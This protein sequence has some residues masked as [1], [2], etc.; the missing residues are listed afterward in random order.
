MA[1]ERARRSDE[2][3]AIR[4]AIDLGMTVLDTA[5]MYADG[6][7]EELV[8]EAIA[9]RR[10]RAFLVDRVLPIHARRRN[11]IAACERSLRRLDTDHLDLYLLHW[12]ETTPLEE[13]VGA[14]Q[15]LVDD[16]KIRY[17]GV[18][19]F[20]LSDMDELVSL[21]GG[22]DVATD[23]VLYNLA[24]RGIEYDL[25]PWCLARNIPVMAYS[26]IQQGRLLD[27]FELKQVAARHNATPAQI[28]LAWV[29]RLD[30]I[31][32]IPKAGNPE[33]VRENRAALDLHLTPDD[34][35]ELDQVFP[36][37]AEP[38]PLEII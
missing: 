2:I 11:T 14:F 22:G 24:H 19:N 38:R 35:A 9:G 15:E 27:H 26:P 20:D 8:G 29:L 12:R 23:Q 1:E 28:A 17:W 6:G 32:A 30:R 25:L 7:T 33:H 18:S 5:E 36:P 3:A 4:L 31:I 37:P 21:P 16:G 34:L 10:H 13:T